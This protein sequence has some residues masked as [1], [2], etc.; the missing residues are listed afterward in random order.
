MPENYYA[1]NT[2]QPL[3]LAPP[4]EHYSTLVPR[5]W[6]LDQNQVPYGPSISQGIS[7]DWQHDSLQATAGTHQ[8]VLPGG[9]P[10]T[11]SGAWAPLAS[12]HASAAF[13]ALGHLEHNDLSGTPEQWANRLLKFHKLYQRGAILKSAQ[14]TLQ[15]D[16]NLWDKLHA[17]VDEIHASPTPWHFEDSV[18]PTCSFH[19][20]RKELIKPWN[21]VSTLVL[22]QQEELNMASNILK[23]LNPTGGL[24][25]QPAAH[26][27]G[28]SACP[29]VNSLPSA[30][31]TW[32]QPTDSNSRP[33]APPH[34]LPAN[35]NHASTHTLFYINELEALG[36]RLASPGRAPVPEF[37]RDQ[38]LH[39]DLH[40]SHG[41]APPPCNNLPPF[42]QSTAP[43]PGTTTTPCSPRTPA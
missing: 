27:I 14:N 15:V 18:D 9:M 3:Y 8:W 30:F 36:G 2:P 22:C 24:F 39:S 6:A 35:N 16:P 7:Q 5:Y 33:D 37:Q 29:H 21:P 13:F 34:P 38:P 40:H 26:T 10:E 41:N 1:M 23:A 17:L 42:C 12:A 19:V 43:F 20:Q 11:P 31:C 28:L 25:D 4:I 32:G